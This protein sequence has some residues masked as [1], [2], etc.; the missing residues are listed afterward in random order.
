MPANPLS[1]WSGVLLAGRCAYNVPMRHPSIFAALLIS[2][3][4]FVS[5]AH[6][7]GAAQTLAERA[8]ASLAKRVPP[9]RDSSTNFNSGQVGYLSDDSGVQSFSCVSTGRFENTLLRLLD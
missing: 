1:F 9:D 3:T 6:A 2:G 8:C 4:L 5:E 7:D